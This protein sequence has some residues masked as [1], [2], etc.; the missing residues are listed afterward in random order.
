MLGHSV[1]SDS[2]TPWTVAHQAP[3]SIGFSRQKYWKGLPCPLPGDL[4]D[5]ETKPVSHSFLH[6][7]AISLPLAPPGKPSFNL[8][9]SLYRHH[10]HTQLHWHLRLQYVNFEETIQFMTLIINELRI[11]QCV[12][13]AVGLLGHKAVLFAVF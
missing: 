3:L 2:V 5:P 11:P 13:P 9:Y 8:N 4:P 12:F 7:Q 10:Y 6:W 1:V